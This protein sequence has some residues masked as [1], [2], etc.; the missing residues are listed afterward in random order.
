LKV[1][2]SKKSFEQETKMLRLLSQHAVPH[3]PRLYGV[4]PASSSSSTAAT[5][6]SHHF[7]ASPVGR[8]M[9]RGSFEVLQAAGLLC[10]CLKAAHTT[11][12]VVHRDVRACNI[13]LVPTDPPAFDSTGVVLLDWACAATLKGSGETECID[14]E[15]TVHFASVAVLQKLKDGD[16]SLVYKPADDL[17]SLVY[18]VFGLMHQAPALQLVKTDYGGILKAWQASAIKYPLLAERLA[19][20]RACDYTELQKSFLKY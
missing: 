2:K 14:Y 1:F 6:S 12:R 11:A 9:A 17:E 8:K 5:S 4:G 19:L 18:T 13:V 3:V 16:R 10:D 15:G 20:A 7:V